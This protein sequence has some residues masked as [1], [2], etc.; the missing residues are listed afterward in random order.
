MI[1]YII[2]LIIPFASFSDQGL[3]FLKNGE[4]FDAYLFYHNEQKTGD[5]LKYAAL[6][7]FYVR[8]FDIAAKEFAL[9]PQ[10]ER[11]R[12]NL[13]PLYIE[14]LIRIGK[15]QLSMKE[16]DSL[17]NYPIE[18]RLKSALP[19]NYFGMDDRGLIKDIN[20]KTLPLTSLNDYVRLAI[21]RF[22]YETARQMIKEKEY[23]F[24]SNPDSMMT[25]SILLLRESK[26]NEAMLMAEKA[27]QLRPND[28]QILKFLEEHEGRASELEQKSTF[29]KE[30]LNQNSSYSQKMSYLQ[31]ILGTIMLETQSQELIQKLSSNATK[32]I[33]EIRPKMQDLPEFLVIEGIVLW[34][35][36][37]S[38]EGIQAIAEALNKDRSYGFASQ[39]LAA[40]NRIEDRLE[41]ALLILN[42]GEAYNIQ[43]SSYFRQLSQVYMSL[44][45][46]EEALKKLDH[47]LK[48]SPFNQ[49]LLTMKKEALKRSVK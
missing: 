10:E 24:N 36:G 46:Y 21:Y 3:D 26:L 1:L 38:K 34:Q 8:R 33:E 44:H 27:A 5:D 11:V 40:M 22:D 17:A 23:F 47:A 7:A 39:T 4:F 48:I 19:F 28:P 45:N 49:T 32:I 37:H 43:D 30:S 12:E 16:G 35:T 9:I 6:S 25:K 13:E 29:L 31:A 42:N 14:S 20:P 15:V 18:V 2:F 41:N